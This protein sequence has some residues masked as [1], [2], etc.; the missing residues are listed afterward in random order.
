MLNTVE[1]KLKEVELHTLSIAQLSK[2]PV[3]GVLSKFW[4]G[5]VEAMLSHL[6]QNGVEVE[7]GE[8]LRDIN[9]VI[10]F[11]NHIFKRLE[12]MNS[13]KN[14]IGSF[15]FRLASVFKSRYLTNFSADDL[16]T[17]SFD[18]SGF[19]NAEARVAL[20]EIFMECSSNS[21]IEF[22]EIDENMMYY[23]YSRKALMEDGERLTI[24]TARE[25]I[26]LAQDYKSVKDAN[27]VSTKFV[28]EMAEKMAKRG[29][30]DAQFRA[31]FTSPVYSYEKIYTVR[32]ILEFSKMSDEQKAAKARHEEIKAQAEKEVKEERSLTRTSLDVESTRVELNKAKPEIRL[33][34]A[35]YTN[36]DFVDKLFDDYEAKELEKAK[37]RMKKARDDGNKAYAI[38]KTHISK[39]LPILEAIRTTKQ[40]FRDEETL[41]LASFML[42]K[43]LLKAVDL[44]AQMV[45]LKTNL[46]EKD[47]E[48]DKISEL[49]TKK[50]DEIKTHQAATTKKSNELNLLKEEYKK[51]VDSMKDEVVVLKKEFDDKAK[52]FNETIDDQMKIIDRLN[53]QL[54]STD[55]LYNEAKEQNLALNKEIT[56]LNAE[57]KKQENLSEE[58]SALKKDLAAAKKGADELKELQIQKKFL[59]DELN[60]KD[61][62]IERIFSST[63]SAPKRADEEKFDNRRVSDIL[64][65]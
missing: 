11:A 41:M 64:K 24:A 20:K 2:T 43:D 59:Q 37:I 28:L 35:N 33:N 19:D 51:R 9:D 56:K 40:E 16:A 52:V 14:N 58:I 42:T 61:A 22:K 5:E 26:N 10:A 32:E 38:L 65:Q 8:N 63:K 34:P 4:D 54:K 50:E 55:K 27:F 3:L 7:K 29:L 36:D 6:A 1:V 47:K 53:V 13:K 18:I 39:G 25:R 12:L 30:L 17:L 23:T 60:K 31:T 46:L 21:F 48:I 57:L 62:M 49:V 45:D 44:Q 15:D